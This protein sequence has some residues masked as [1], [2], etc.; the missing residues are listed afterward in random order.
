VQRYG[1]NF[2]EPDIFRLYKNP[3]GLDLDFQK[4]VR[5]YDT[6]DEDRFEATVR[7]RRRFTHDFSVGL[8]VKYNLVDVSNLDTDGVPPLLDV[9][10]RQ[11]EQVFQGV[12]A[13]AGWRAVDNQLNPRQGYWIRANAE[14]YGGPYGGDGN[15]VQTEIS[16]DGYFPF[17]D[18]AVEVVPGVHVGLDVGV[19]DEYGSTHDVPYTERFQL[20]GINTLRGFEFRGVGPIDKASGFTLGGETYLAGTVE[21]QYPL[22]SI[23]QPG[24]YRQIETLRATL[25]FDWGVLNPDAYRLDLG[26]LRTSIGFGVGL[27]Y[28]L[29]LTL[30]F[31]FPIDM[32]D[33]D[34]RRTF[35]FS[36]GLR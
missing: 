36:I 17:G 1:V 7:L 29:P 22:Y 4:R 8:G 33:G 11:G 24:T 26:E 13:D 28:P 34:I 9:Q 2:Y 6:H 23:T 10:E 12:V 18:P 20:G 3:I 19:S 16:A 5:L 32:Q 30:N 21:Y 15:F 35:S 27:A 25:F 31:G 14:W